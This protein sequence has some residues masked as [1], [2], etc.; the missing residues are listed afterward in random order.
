MSDEVYT[1]GAWRVRHEKQDEFVESWTALGAH[2]RNLASPPGP[3]TLL[4]S[5]DDP[6]EFYSFGSWQSLEA[7]DAM[8]S[9]PDT[10]AMIGALMALC[11]DG[12][13]GTFRVVARG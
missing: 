3:G 2:F 9:H 13:P 12:R 10:P 7:I 5:I 6:Q 4:Q 11:E 8:R 1:L